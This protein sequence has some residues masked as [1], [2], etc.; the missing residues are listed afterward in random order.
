MDNKKMEAEG[1]SSDEP[2]S[3]NVIHC[4]SLNDYFIYSEYTRTNNYMTRFET[5]IFFK[6]S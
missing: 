4:L 3:D 6:G 2:L 1:L 5:G